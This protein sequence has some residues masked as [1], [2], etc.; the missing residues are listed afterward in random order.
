MTGTIS[1]PLPVGFK[2]ASVG[3]PLVMKVCERIIVLDHGKV[4]WIGTHAELIVSTPLYKELAQHQ[5]LA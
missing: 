2:T 1:R 4:V 5:L 3:L